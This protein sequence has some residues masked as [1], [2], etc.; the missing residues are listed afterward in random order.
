MIMLNKLSYWPRFRY[1][2]FRKCNQEVYISVDFL[3]QKLLKNIQCDF[4]YKQS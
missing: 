4:F 1:T 2:I 3:L